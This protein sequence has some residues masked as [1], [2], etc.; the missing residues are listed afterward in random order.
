[1]RQ[2]RFCKPGFFVVNDIITPIDGQTHDYELLFHLD[3][4]RPVRTDAYPGAVLTDFGGKYD[5]LMIPMD[6]VDAPV[7]T[8]IA[9]AQTEPCM[10]G[11]YNGRGEHDLHPS[12]TVS[13][14]VSGAGECRFTT[15]LLPMRAGDAMPEVT[16]SDDGKVKVLFEG[17]AYTFDLN[18]LDQ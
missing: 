9:S 15:L 17:K 12:T 14:C 11:W 8:K 5:L 18:A 13:R 7:E 3:T 6:C 10:R 4:T 2:V 1:M 16:A